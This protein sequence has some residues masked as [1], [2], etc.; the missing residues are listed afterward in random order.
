[1]CAI[2]VECGARCPVTFG[3]LPAPVT[4]GA[5]FFFLFHF[6]FPL[7]FLFFIPAAFFTITTSIQ[8]AHFLLVL[9]LRESR[10][11]KKRRPGTF[12]FFFSRSRSIKKDYVKRKKMNKKAGDEDTCSAKHLQSS[13]F[14]FKLGRDEKKGII[15]IKSDC[16]GCHDER[17]DG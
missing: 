7:F 6:N 17:I 16:G 8:N 15:I 5:A 13:A 11:L 12:H 4:H 2:R 9:F 14:L 3:P 10:V 1:M